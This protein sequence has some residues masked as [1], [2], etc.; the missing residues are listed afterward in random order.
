MTNRSDLKCFH[1]SNKDVS[2]EGNSCCWN[3]IHKISTF[4]IILLLVHWNATCKDTEFGEQ[5]QKESLIRSGCVVSSEDSVGN[6]QSILRQGQAAQGCVLCLSRSAAGVTRRCC[7]LWRL[8]ALLL[9]AVQLALHNTTAD[10]ELLTD[11]LLSSW[12]RALWTLWAEHYFFMTWRN[13]HSEPTILTLER[14]FWT[15]N[16]Q[17][18]LANVS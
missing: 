4:M 8:A 5:T 16:N 7:T 12:M 1:L 15:V 11:T 9:V 18:Y 6:P 2:T 13:P 14:I 10:N 3:S 17:E